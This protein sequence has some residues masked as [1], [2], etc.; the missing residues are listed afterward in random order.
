MPTKMSI[1][2]LPTKVSVHNL[3]TKMNYINLL[4]KTIYEF[5]GS[6]EPFS[7]EF[8]QPDA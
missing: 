7:A 2:N 1:H 6:R 3:P 5:D 8:S 4:M